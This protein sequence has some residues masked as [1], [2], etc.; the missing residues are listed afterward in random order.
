[1]LYFLTMLCIFWKLTCACDTNK[2]L[3][4]LPGSMLLLAIFIVLVVE[5]NLAST[6]FPLGWSVFV[7]DAL[8]LV[9]KG[10]QSNS[11]FPSR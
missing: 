4:F 7:G 2:A 1:M 10:N 8:V 11:G 5:R 9:L 3:D 6:R